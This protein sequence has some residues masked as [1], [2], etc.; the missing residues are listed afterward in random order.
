MSCA[1]LAMRRELLLLTPILASPSP[2]PTPVL[3]VPVPVPYPL[4]LPKLPLPYLNPTPNPGPFLWL[5][6]GR[7][8]RHAISPLSWPVQAV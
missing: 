7:S 5:L 6:R 3:P 2:T 8:E 4:P 1:E